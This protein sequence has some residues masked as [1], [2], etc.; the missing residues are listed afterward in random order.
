[1]DMKR[2]SP[3]VKHFSTKKVTIKAI[4]IAIGVSLIYYFLKDNLLLFFSLI[5][6]P[7]T[8]TIKD[9]YILDV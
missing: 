5:Y 3:L 6:F 9:I 8:K 7:L 1:M 4:L 2:L